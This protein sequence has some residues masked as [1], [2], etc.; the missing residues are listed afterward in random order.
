M[1]SSKQSPQ[2]SERLVHVHLVG[3]TQKQSLSSSLQAVWRQP[4]AD[5]TNCCS[6][7]ANHDRVTSFNPFPRAFYQFLESPSGWTV[8]KW[9]FNHQP[10]LLQAAKPD[11]S[12]RGRRGAGTFPCHALLG[13]GLARAQRSPA[14][15]TRLFL[16]SHN[17]LKSAYN[18]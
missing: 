1:L 17:K 11:H 18:L 9:G 13:A 6:P 10:W 14:A 8:I 5:P 4:H 16:C 3:A 12:A 15:V 2:P 7:T